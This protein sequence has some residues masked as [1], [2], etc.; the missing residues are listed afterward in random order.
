MAKYEQM[1]QAIKMLKQLRLPISKEQIEALREGEISYVNK[2]IAP[3]IKSVIEKNSTDLQ[4]PYNL[5]VRYDPKK[6]VEVRAINITGNVKPIEQKPKR[7]PPRYGAREEFWSEFVDYCNKHKGLYANMS[8]DNH[9]WMGKSMQRIIKGCSINVV[10]REDSC[11]VEL[12]IRGETTE[13]SKR[14]YDALEKYRPK[15]DDILPDLEWERRNETKS[16]RIRTIKPYHYNNPDE[17]QQIIE[18]FIRVHSNLWKC[19]HIMEN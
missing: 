7:E 10:I 8:R 19:F 4:N 2:K 5:L 11:W 15:I 14:I 12:W 9:A 18:F 3:K 16:S 6:G 1:L 17:R 13:E